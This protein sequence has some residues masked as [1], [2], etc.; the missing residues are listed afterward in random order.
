MGRHGPGTDR[1]WA[2]GCS[3]DVVR[4]GG[5]GIFSPAGYARPGRSSSTTRTSDEDLHISSIPTHPGPDAGFQEPNPTRIASDPTLATGTVVD[6]FA[7]QT[8]SSAR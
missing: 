5:I 1:K 8:S 6:E 3:Y 2:R 4:C 7:S